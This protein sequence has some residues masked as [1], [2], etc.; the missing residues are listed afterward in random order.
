[1]IHLC[2]ARLFPPEA[3]KVNRSTIFYEKLRPEFIRTYHLPLS[4]DGF[5]TFQESSEMSELDGHLIGAS[6]VLHESLHKY[7][8]KLMDPELIN[9][10]LLSTSRYFQCKE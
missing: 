10:I 8:E 6:K 9:L 7:V 2:V 5:T 3:P 1:M 4:S